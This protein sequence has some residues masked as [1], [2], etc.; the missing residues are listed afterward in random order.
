MPW[1]TITALI[2]IT[3]LLI[4]ALLKGINGAL[5]AGGLSLLAGLAGFEA[6]FIK[7]RRSIGKKD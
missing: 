3:T 6:G 2:C 1:K 4:V 7:A 5:L